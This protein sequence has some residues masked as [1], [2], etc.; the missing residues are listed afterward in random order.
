MRSYK[1]YQKNLHFFFIRI[2]WYGPKMV[3]MVSETIHCA[4][5]TSTIFFFFFFKFR[6]CISWCGCCFVR[7]LLCISFSFHFIL[8]FCSS[9]E[10]W[11]Q[12]TWFGFCCGQR[13]SLWLWVRCRFCM[14]PTHFRLVSPYLVFMQIRKCLSTHNFIYFLRT[15]FNLFVLILMSQL[16]I[17]L[18]SCKWRIAKINMRWKCIIYMRNK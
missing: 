7:V 14:P 8:F 1:F 5:G 10:D 6:H 2:I 11:K 3:G 18:Y 16:V 9:I 12:A 4:T 15:E 13:N 17:S